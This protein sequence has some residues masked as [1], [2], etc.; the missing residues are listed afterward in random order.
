MKF[1]RRHP[2]RCAK[3]NSQ[4]RAVNFLGGQSPAHPSTPSTQRLLE[5]SFSQNGVP[6]PPREGP[7][8]PP[9][10]AES[11]SALSALHE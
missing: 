8:V 7:V 10:S 3:P 4:P 5:G 6:T 2:D 9:R 11:T 1:T